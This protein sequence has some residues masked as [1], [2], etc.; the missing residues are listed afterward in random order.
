[1]TR[2][3]TWHC[4]CDDGEMVEHKEAAD[5]IKSLIGITKQLLDRYSIENI[6]EA[7]ELIKVIEKEIK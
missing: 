5:I 3:D 1:M 7:E 4:E 6:E 2:Y